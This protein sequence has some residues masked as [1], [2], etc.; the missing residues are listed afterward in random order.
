MTQSGHARGLGPFDKE[1]ALA[2][3]INGFSLG[4]NRR[5]AA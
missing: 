1:G 2:A 5:F 3:A 4:G